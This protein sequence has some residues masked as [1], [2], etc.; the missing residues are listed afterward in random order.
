MLQ[1][2]RISIA[3]KTF[4]NASFEEVLNYILNGTNIKSKKVAGGIVLVKN[5]NKQELYDLKLQL[6]DRKNQPISGASVR[7]PLTGQSASSNAQGEEAIKLAPGVYDVTVTHVGYAKK[8][9]NSLRVD[10]SNVKV[11]PVTLT[12]DDNE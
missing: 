11:Y 9:L 12:E 1:L 4:R 2:E 10:A 3:E 5:G 6:V 7:I 8:E